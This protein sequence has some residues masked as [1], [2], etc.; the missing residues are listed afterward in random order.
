M[1]VRLACF[2]RMASALALAMAALCFTVES[3]AAVSSAELIRSAPHRHGRFEARLRFAAGDGVVSSFFLWKD[4]SERPGTAWNEIDIEKIGTDCR[5][6]SSNAIYGNPAQHHTARVTVAADLCSELHTHTIEWTPS[7]LRWMVDGVEVRRLEPEALAAFER[8][9]SAGLQLRF[10]VWPGDESF[11]GRFSTAILPT[12]QYIDS[13]TYSEYT[14]GAGTDGG[15]FTPLW[16]ESCDG[17][18]G[19]GWSYG[20][21]SSPLGHSTHARANVTVADGFCVLTLRED[22]VEEGDAG[23]SGSSGGSSS[24][25]GGAAPAPP[26]GG[27]PG[28]G[29]AAHG[30]ERSRAGGCGLC[31]GSTRAPLA[32]LSL[33]LALLL[34]RRRRPGAQRQT[35]SPPSSVRS[36]APSRSMSL[37]Y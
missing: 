11:G 21:W 6:Y 23:S 5:G 37:K 35:T 29:G 32:V 17:A 27:A 8:D 9:A 30:R 2:G 25:S 15:D 31:V 3:E 28:A 14:P 33:A 16:S 1:T 22:G 36:I 20:S 13:V 12:R 24:G 18:L 10:N 7:L 4:G 34:S 26:P 19:P